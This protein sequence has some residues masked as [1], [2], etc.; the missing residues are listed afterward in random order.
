MGRN[1]KEWDGIKRSWT[2]VGYRLREKNGFKVW[3]Q[4]DKLNQTYGRGQ[5]DWH[6]QDGMND[7]HENEKS[8]YPCLKTKRY[9]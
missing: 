3:I 7:K 5:M 4:R 8:K 1:I 2:K 6:K 9:L